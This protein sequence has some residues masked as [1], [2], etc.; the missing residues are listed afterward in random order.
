MCHSDDD[1]AELFLAQHLIDAVNTSHN[2]SSENVSASDDAIN[3]HLVGHI[4]D[5][6]EAV[7]SA[8]RSSVEMRLLEQGEQSNIE[9]DTPNKIKNIK[10]QEW[11]NTILKNDYIVPSSQV[12]GVQNQ[13]R[14]FKF[15]IS[16]YSIEAI[17]SF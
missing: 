14:V 13:F 16:A 8:H 5:D 7:S 6:E 1:G 10:S 12:A 17:L 11:L 2:I 3:P 15:K 9:T 4:S